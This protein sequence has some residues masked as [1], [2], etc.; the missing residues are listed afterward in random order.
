MTPSS[1]FKLSKGAKQVKKTR[2]TGRKPKGRRDVVL[3][4]NIPNAVQCLLWAR[5]AGRCEM[6]GCNNALWKSPLTQQGLKL[7]EMGHI[8]SFSAEGPRGNAGLAGK[9]INALSNIILV[10]PTCHLLIDH[11]KEG[12]QYSAAW[13]QKSK[14]LH[15]RRVEIATE[16]RPEMS[17]HILFYSAN[18]RDNSASP[19]F[20]R[21]ALALFPQRYPADDKPIDLSTK[22]SALQER[23]Q[24]FWKKEREELTAKFEQRVRARL[25]SGDISHLSVFGL[26]PQPLLVFL[27]T[28]L[29][30]IPQA[31]VY[32]LHREPQ[33]WAWP[34][35]GDLVPFSVTEP[36]SFLAQPVLVLSLS[37]SIGNDRVESVLGKNVAIWRVSIGK[38]SND[39]VK[40]RE[41]LLEFRKLMRHV[42][43]RIKSCHGQ[44]TVL[45][46]FPAT[47]VS[48]AIDL[49]RIRMPKADMPWTIYDQVN[50]SGGFVRA[51]II[52]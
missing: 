13:L 1:Y 6:I 41:Q 32:Q 29:T 49:G 42:M 14:S 25:A 35:R 31:D 5:A 12:V 9:E 33:G 24:S 19:S 48:V 22:N 28:L 17:S 20:D 39:F 38:P 45:H 40:S 10:C 21:A 8:Y 44:N 52:Q 30:D 47:P 7:G 18:I 27:G 3:S 15:E 43:D 11:D 4:R 37:A 50:Q 51:L 2:K 23:N 16:I 46:I 34:D 26:A 36:T